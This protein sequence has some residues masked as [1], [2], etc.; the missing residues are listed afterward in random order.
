MKKLA[1][2]TVILLSLIGCIPKPAEPTPTS[3]PVTPTLGTLTVH[4]I[5]VGQ[6]DAIL[7]QSPDGRNMLIDGGDKSPGVVGYLKDKGINEL[8]VVVLTHPH[9]DHVG[10]LVDVM[11]RIPVKQVW[12]N[13]SASTSPTYISFLTAIR[14]SN[15]I[16]NDARRGGSIPLGNLTFSILHPTDAES[17]DLNDDSIVLR[18]QH[19]AVSFLFTGD[20][21]SDS[22]KSMLAAG[23][24]TQTTI[25]KLGHHGSRTSS[26]APFVKTVL[27]KA[28]VYMAGQG[29]D[30]YH[31]HPE[32]LGTMAE[33]K[34]DVF[35]TDV[36][37]TVVITSDG[38]SYTVTPQKEGTPRAPPTPVRPK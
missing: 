18:L 28:T 36:N 30:Y 17:K 1:L 23:Q 9:A 34:A 16:Y 8:D 24:V 38:Q 13:G 3:V 27:P 31:P 33:I 21:T 7:V 32:T 19:G 29:N 2:L 12:N 6:G 25:L 22:E 35:G 10:G 37:G 26:S 20:A 5:D 11:R 15:A 14:S 4:Y